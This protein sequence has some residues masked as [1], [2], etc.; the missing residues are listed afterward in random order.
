LC[1]TAVNVAV[2]VKYLIPPPLR[3]TDNWV[4][5]AQFFTASSDFDIK[6]EVEPF[7][8]NAFYFVMLEM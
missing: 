7:S 8:K 2:G 5:S 6:Q 3:A 1:E 4:A